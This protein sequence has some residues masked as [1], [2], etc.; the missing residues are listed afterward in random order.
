MKTREAS[1]DP[2]LAEWNSGL[3][4]FPRKGTGKRL[5]LLALLGAVAWG[6]L[7]GIAAMALFAIRSVVQ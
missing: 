2:R 7:A 4:V 1:I 5:V 3:A 6:G